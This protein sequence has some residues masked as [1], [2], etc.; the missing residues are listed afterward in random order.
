MGEKIGLL[1]KDTFREK[2]GHEAFYFGS[3]YCYYYFQ[4]WP[5]RPVPSVNRGGGLQSQTVDW[6]DRPAAALGSVQQTFGPVL[7]PA[8]GSFVGPHC[9]LCDTGGLQDSIQPYKH[10]QTS[11]LVILKKQYLLKSFI[12]PCLERATEW[13]N[14]IYASGLSP[15]G[16]ML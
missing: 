3:K 7:P 16:R 10:L 2:T 1:K 9:F 11:N 8:L 14:K 5:F 15:P 12:F 6:M 13:L 4:G